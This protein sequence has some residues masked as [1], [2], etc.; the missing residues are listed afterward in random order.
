[1]LLAVDHHRFDKCRLGFLAAELESLLQYLDVLFELT[2]LHLLLDSSFKLHR[3]LLK[4]T[5]GICFLSL[6]TECSPLQRH[7]TLD[8]LGSKGH[9]VLV[10]HADALELGPI[11]HPL[12]SR[13]PKILHTGLFGLH[14][15]STKLHHPFIKRLN[16]LILSIETIGVCR[17]SCNWHDQILSLR[18]LV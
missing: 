14:L 4:A 1:M 18:V 5:L 9:A 16:G 17:H 8:V 6:G 11:A 3:L 10:L 2:S 13:L 7:V 12:A 15:Q